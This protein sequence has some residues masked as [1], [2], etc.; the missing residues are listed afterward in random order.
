MPIFD[1][2]FIKERFKKLLIKNGYSYKSLGWGKGGRQNLRFSILTKDIKKNSSVLDLGCGFGDL[3]KFLKEEIDFEG[4]Y[5]GVDLVEGML[6]IG[7]ENHKNANFINS[8]VSNG[9]PEIPKHDFVIASGLMN[10]K[11]NSSNNKEYIEHILKIMFEKSKVSL[12]CDF[13]TTKVDFQN[14]IAWHTDPSWVINI[15][16]SLTKRWL[17]R[18]DYMPYEFSL[19]LYKDQNINSSSVFSSINNKY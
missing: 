12:A 9:L 8:D 15:A 3:L 16:S 5:T 10:L 13:M 1:T 6:K 2:Q 17:L 11:L 19:I 7:K 14:E 18:N 4:Q